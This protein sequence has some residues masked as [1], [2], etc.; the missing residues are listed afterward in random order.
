M[1]LEEAGGYKL[2]VI[3]LFKRRIELSLNIKNEF[4]VYGKDFLAAS[5]QL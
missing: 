2:S 4:E 3:E 5:F 1:K